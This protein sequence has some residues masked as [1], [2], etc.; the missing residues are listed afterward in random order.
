M[1][2]SLTLIFHTSSV[3]QG[4][5]THQGQIPQTV[6]NG[7]ECLSDVWEWKPESR[8][9]E[10]PRHLYVTNGRAM[11]EEGL[12]IGQVIRRVVT[13]KGIKVPWLAQQL[14]CH[15]NNVYLIFSRQWIDTNTLMKL[16]Q[17]LG[18][19][20]FADLSRSYREQQ[21]QPG[22]YINGMGES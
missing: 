5:N 14:G 17:I 13:R 18:H 16:A 21:G 22:G 15:R 2:L 12:H 6:C 11:S 8:T 4:T 20:F 19:D 10:I 3:K 1:Q 9:G 7:V